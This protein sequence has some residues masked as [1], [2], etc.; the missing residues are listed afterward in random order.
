MYANNT[1]HMAIAQMFHPVS[2]LFFLTGL[3]YRATKKL[4]YAAH[5]TSNSLPW[6]GLLRNQFRA[7]NLAF[8]AGKCGRNEVAASLNIELYSGHRERSSMLN[9]YFFPHQDYSALSPDITPVNTFRIALNPFFGTN[10]PLLENQFNFS[11]WDNPY[12]FVDV[13][14]RLD[15]ACQP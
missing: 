6:L 4:H 13:K 11:Y 7:A 8:V 3:L 15:Q 9:A 5:T 2:I 12:T 14:D 1:A 10:F